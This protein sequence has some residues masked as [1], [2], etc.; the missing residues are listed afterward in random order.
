MLANQKENQV[1]SLCP[2]QPSR[3]ARRGRLL[4]AAFILLGGLALLLSVPVAARA[5]EPTPTPSADISVTKSGNEAAPVGGTITYNL[6][7]SN[8]STDTATNVVLTDVIP[9]NTT[10]VSA[11]SPTGMVSFS[12][13]TL[14]VTFASISP[15]TPGDETNPPFC[16]TGS[17]TLVVSVNANTPRGTVVSNTVTGTAGTP[18][19]NPDNNSA[20][21]L[22]IIT[23]PFA[24]DILISEFRLRG[25]GGVADEYIEIYNNADTPHDVQAA[26]GSAGYA[27]AASDGGIRCTIPNGT[28]L[29]ARGHYLCTNSAYSLGLYPGGESKT[30]T[31]DVA[32]ETDIPDNAGIAIFRTSNTENFNL[33][34]RLD[35]AGSIA[36][37]NTLYREGAGYPALSQSNLDYALFRDLCGKAGSVT[38]FGGCLVA[39]V[40][41]DSNDNAVDFVYVETGGNPSGNEAARLGAPGPENFQSPVQRNASF[42]VNLLDPCASSA[43]PPNRG[44]DFT[45]LPANNSTFGTLEIRRT[46]TNNTGEDVTRLRWR[47][48]DIT[49]YPAPPGIAD[50]RPMTST[51]LVVTVDRA[52]CGSG[53]SSVTVQGTTL[54]QPPAQTIGGGFNSS[55][56]SGTVTLE[57]PLLSGES[58]DVRFLF[59][60]M[61]PGNFKFFINVEALTREPEIIVPP[62]ETP[63]RLL[64]GAPSGPSVRQPR[65]GLVAVPSG[66]D[67][68][69]GA[70]SP[71]TPGSVSAPT[72]TPSKGVSAPITRPQ[73]ISKVRR[74]VDSREF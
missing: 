24:G 60:I 8:G 39:G 57:T 35:A 53:T 13:N 9:A 74:D 50:L 11:D 46:V 64:P 70:P 41:K 54:E 27:V 69:A 51:P 29:P 17:A 71:Q 63:E 56:S 65:K 14:T 10:F 42:A 31:G 68:G 58:L 66:G 23:G 6:V 19:P 22:T 26:D 59:G 61:Q 62:E 38:I 72:A 20:T 32:Y 12:N 7:V 55:L 1:T 48:I 34:T 15:C 43:S 16:E 25:P 47:I 40:P 5:Q 28:I 3:Q 30:A 36:E 52:P 2:S 45:S 18:D 37:E 49:T 67:K 4:H 33:D 44:R 21:A 73:G